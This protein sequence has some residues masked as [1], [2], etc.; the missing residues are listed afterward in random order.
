MAQDASEK[1][2][3]ADER[4]VR[5]IAIVTGASRGLGAAI[6]ERLLAPHRRLVCVAR[7]GNDALAARAQASGA[8][9]DYLRHDLSDAQ[10]TDRLADALSALLRA[11]RDARRFVLV[12]NAGIVEPIGRIEALRSEGIAAALQVNLASLMRLTAAF[13]DA[14]D[15][16]SGERRIL[17]ISSGAARHPIAGWAPYCAT[18]AAVD[19]FTRCIVDEQSRRA[20]PARACALAPGVLDTD[21]QSTIRSADFPSIDRFRELK[22]QGGLISPE[23][24]AARIVAYLER[25]D[26]GSRPV[27][28]LREHAGR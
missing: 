10:D 15:G 20:N 21:M 4:R 11:H 5:E 28:D 8:P 27:D 26:F 2:G 25:D 17:G 24:A 22:T 16:A 23:Q 1:T 7:S 18:K 9:L 12:N 19:M 13:L 14:T 3:A 6:A